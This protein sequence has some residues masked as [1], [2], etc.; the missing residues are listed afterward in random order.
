MWVGTCLPGPPAKHATDYSA[1]KDAQF[2]PI[3]AATHGIPAQKTSTAQFLPIPAATH[4]IPAQ[5]T[6]TQKLKNSGWGWRNVS[7]AHPWSAQ[8]IFVPIKHNKKTTPP[9]MER[10]TVQL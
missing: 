8:N 10:R 3:P 5:K 7:P 9:P 6:S 4:G 2:L 1:L